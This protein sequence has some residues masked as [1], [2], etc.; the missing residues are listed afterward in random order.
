MEQ[1]PVLYIVLNVS[2]YR[3][4][5]HCSLID[6]ILIP[7][8]ETEAQRQVTFQ[9]NQPGNVDVG[10]TVWQSNSRQSLCLYW[11]VRLLHVARKA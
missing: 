1:Y 8:E 4:F 11:L 3:F 10:P 9:K 2:Q 6:V 5:N 7:C